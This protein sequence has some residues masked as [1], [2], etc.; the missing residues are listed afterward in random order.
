L[1]T[2]GRWL[3]MDKGSR[4]QPIAVPPATVARVAEIKALGESDSDDAIAPLLE[5]L[6]D[7]DGNVREAAVGALVCLGPERVMSCLPAL[8]RGTGPWKPIA[9]ILGLLATAESCALLGAALNDPS[10]DVRVTAS[11][12]LVDAGEAS[13]PVLVGALSHTDPAVRSRAAMS[14]GRTKARSAVEALMAACKDD[15]PEVRME[16]VLALAAI[17]DE[18]AV[19]ALLGVLTDPAEVVRQA[20]PIALAEI[21]TPAAFDG[22][23]Q[24]ASSD[25]GMVRWI[26]KSELEAAGQ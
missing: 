8:P 24:C 26:A 6:R 14:L 4:G 5:A 1:R 13:R 25:D 3:D 10:Q 18:Q 12:A 16:A 22:L 15:A 23:R 20:V 11:L 9:R 7:G 19:P 21:A 2:R 17:R